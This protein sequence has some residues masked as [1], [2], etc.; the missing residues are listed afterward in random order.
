MVCSPFSQ[1]QV[2]SDSTQSKDLLVFMDFFD[3]ISEEKKYECL[4]NELRIPETKVNT[5]GLRCIRD[6]SKSNCYANIDAL[7]ISINQLAQSYMIHFKENPK[8]YKI[9]NS[10]KKIC[11][12]QAAI[13][14][15]CPDCYEAWKEDKTKTQRAFFKLVCSKPHLVVLYKVDEFP[16]WPAKLFY[17]KDGIANVECFG[18]QT[19]DDI[20]LSQ[21]FLYSD[22]IPRESSDDK[23]KQ[24]R[25]NRAYR[26][27][28]KHIKLIEE[29]FGA[30]S[31]VSAPYKIQ[32]SN[33]EQHLKDMFPSVYTES[34]GATDVL[35]TKATSSEAQSEAEEPFFG[36]QSTSNCLTTFNRNLSTLPESNM[37]ISIENDD[38][39]DSSDDAEEW[40]NQNHAIK[41][42]S[43]FDI[44]DADGNQSGQLDAQDN[45]LQA[46]NG[47]NSNTSMNENRPTI[48]VKTKDIS[49]NGR[50]QNIRKRRND[51]MENQ[52][53]QL[54]NN[55]KC[56]ASK[57]RNSSRG[58]EEEI[59]TLDKDRVATEDTNATPENT[60]V[61]VLKEYD[62]VNKQIYDL[63][64]E[65]EKLKTRKDELGKI[66]LRK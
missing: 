36:E 60:L 41:L 45:V 10:F 24:E 55:K 26:D 32:V 28:E 6:L 38:S 34:V 14:K 37:D 5:I 51:L 42:E 31:F 16:I 43:T 15:K 12:E 25:L 19:E 4:Q 56:N 59:I 3:E 11:F 20:P 30:G 44:E 29:K 33:L 40:G 46:Y 7:L 58:G 21:C 17:I 22:K 13:I 48:A 1:N 47:D 35:Q 53:D 27:V 65:L 57:S 2:A 49:E 66:L 18:D 63:K 50:N 39:Y 54:Q 64:A 23:N 61:L 9:A 8:I 62:D 52:A